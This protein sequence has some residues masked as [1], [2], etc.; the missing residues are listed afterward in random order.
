MCTQPEM[1][2]VERRVEAPRII[3][4]GDWYCRATIEG[5]SQTDDRGSG[6]V[7]SAG[8][9]LDGDRAE[10]WIEVGQRII[11]FQ[12]GD[13]QDRCPCVED[14][15]QVARAAVAGR[16]DGGEMDEVWSVD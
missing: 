12:A 16:I 15:R 3:E 7:G 2:D 9:P 1:R 8:Q 5:I 6:A 13:R 14:D 4:K 11:V 10:Q